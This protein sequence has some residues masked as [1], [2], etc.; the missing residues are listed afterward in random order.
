VDDALRVDAQGPNFLF[1]INDTLIAQVTDPDYTG[2]EIG[3]YAE[4][5]DSPQAHIHFDKL[6]ISDVDIALTCEVVNEATLYVR[7]GPGKTYPQ[8]AV[9]SNGDSVKALGISP[10]RWIKIVVEG[11]DE[12]GWVSYDDGFLK[13]TPTID[14]FPI[15]SP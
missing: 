12:P 15:V 1:H 13:C 9:L 14:L 3:F 8:T 4:A 2:G 10:N 7:S 11:S 6:T 5:F